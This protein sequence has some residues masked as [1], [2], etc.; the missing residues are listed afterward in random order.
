MQNQ[1]TIEVLEESKKNNVL[2]GKSE[3]NKNRS[4]KML[5]V[6]GEEVKGDRRKIKN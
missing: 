6:L 4:Y 3:S 5:W 2:V 1:N